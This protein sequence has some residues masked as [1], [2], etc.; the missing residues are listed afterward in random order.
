VKKVDLVGAGM[1]VFGKYP[2]K[3]GRD[4]L[5]EAVREAV[6]HVD[7]GIDIKKDV[8]AL[9]I[10][11]FT[12]ELYEHQGHI[13]ALAAEWLGLSGIPAF[14]TESA[15]ASS[16]AAFTTGYWAIA[17]GMYDLVMVGG[18]EKMTGLNTAGVIDALSIAADN[19]Y[20]LPTGITFPGLFALMAQEYFEK[21]RV[22]WEDL[23]A[24]SIKNHHNGALNPRAQFRSEILDIARKTG[25]KKGVKFEDEMTFLKSSSN[26]AVAY[27]IRLFDCCPISD[28]AAVALLASRDISKNFT[29]KPLHIEGLGLGTDTITLSGRTDL[30]SSK[31]IVNAARAAYQMAGVKPE[32]I[33]VAEVHDC[34]TIN[35]ALI[36]EDLG[37]FRRGE[38]LKAAK[39]GRTALSGDK[40]VNMD[41]GLKCKGHPVGATGIG[42]IHEIWLQLRNE[43]GARQVKGNPEIGLT[44]NV[45]GSNASAIVL[46]FKRR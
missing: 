1:T 40:P 33:D 7:K 16:S 38:G 32:E 2:D 28:G 25:S 4:L 19:I 8:K 9:F 34:F 15:C 41:G 44:C 29:E 42:M 14:R 37:F 23:Q 26:P 21:Y 46:I 11:Y 24:I 45:G 27:P 30:T 43:A 17:S 3:T 20:E 6:S 22:T 12:P 5:L 35:E 18:V 39:E 31:A 13:G 10:G 36:T